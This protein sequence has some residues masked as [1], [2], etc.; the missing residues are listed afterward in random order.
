[1]KCI[2]PR[3]GSTRRRGVQWIAERVSSETLTGGRRTAASSSRRPSATNLIVAVIARG[4]RRGLGGG[5]RVGLGRGAVVVVSDPDVIGNQCF[6]LG[7]V[8]PVT[9][10]PGGGLLLYPPLAP[11]PSGL[12]KESCAVIDQ[13]RS[14]RGRRSGPSWK[15]AAV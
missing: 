9:G 5:V 4:S 14:M 10:T 3:L 2:A 13:L 15:A 8:V 6:P 7:C 11:D 12:A 1:M